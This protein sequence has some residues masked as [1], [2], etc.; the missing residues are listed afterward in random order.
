MSAS[1]GFKVFTSTDLVHWTDQ[2]W[3]LVEDDSWGDRE[4]WAPEVIEKGGTFYIYY[5]VQERICVA[6]SSSPLGPFKQKIHE[7]ME[8]E[9]IRIDSH[10]F[11]DDDGKDYL[12]Y[13][14]FNNGNEIWGAELNSDMRTIEQSSMR[15]MI[16]PDQEWEK[17]RAN[18][19]E[20]PFVIKHKGTYYLTYSG[21]HVASP[22]YG[23]GYATASHPLG[24]WTKY[25]YNPILK[26]MSYVH[27]PGH[28]CFTTSPDG[29]EHWIV[30]HALIDGRSDNARMI[31]T[32]PFTWDDDGF[33]VF[34]EPV[35]PDTVLSRPSTN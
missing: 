18:V 1:H 8:P 6:S 30:Y 12:Y 19:N 27:G 16:A 33:P 11:Q 9:S 22:N 24:P 31:R 2:G 3:V 10:V 5:T 15:L 28:H 14:A 23:V 34:G 20:G 35:P 13:V 4:F 7:P 17:N 25:A 29:S 21:S 32:Q 26:S